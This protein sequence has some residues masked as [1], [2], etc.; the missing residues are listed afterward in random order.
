MHNKSKL[1]AVCMMAIMLLQTSVGAATS[2]GTHS[3]TSNGRSYT[4]TYTLSASKATTGITCSSANNV[5]AGVYTYYNEG[6]SKKTSGW[7]Y[8]SND[9]GTSAYVSWTAGTGRTIYK[10]ISRGWTNNVVAHTT[11]N[12]V[13]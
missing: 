6:N 10:A 11:T 7:Y 8:N 4:L 9:P 1:I 13:E 2:S 3:G 5:Q 12:N